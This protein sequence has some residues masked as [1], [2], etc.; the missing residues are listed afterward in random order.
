MINCLREHLKKVIPV[1]NL[2]AN[3]LW[4]MNIHEFFEGKNV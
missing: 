2:F 4:N 3:T 1:E